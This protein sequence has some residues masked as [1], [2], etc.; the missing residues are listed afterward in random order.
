MVFLEPPRATLG[1]LRAALAAASDDVVT[2][3]FDFGAT[4]TTTTTTTDGNDDDDDGGD[5]PNDE[6][7]AYVSTLAS[8]LADAREWDAKVWID[9]LSPYLLPALRSSSGYPPE[10]PDGVVPSV[11]SRLRDAARDAAA[12]HDDDSSDEEDEYG[13]EE[14][15]D[16][17]FSLAYGGKILLHQTKLRLRRGHRYALVGQ[18]GVGKTTLMNAI[19]AGKLEGWPAEL[20]T[21]YVDSGS[22]VDPDHEAKVAFDHLVKITGKSDDECRGLLSQLKFTDAMMSGTIGELSGGWQMKLR[23]AQAVLVDADILLLDEPTNHLDTKT[24]RWLVDYLAGLTQTTVLIVSHD[25]PFL[26]EV[27]SDGE[28]F[29]LFFFSRGRRVSEGRADGGFVNRDLTMPGRTRY[30]PPTAHHHHN[31]PPTHTRAR[32]RSA[33]IHYEQ[34]PQWGPHRKLVHYAGRMS[35]FVKKQPQAKH[36]FELATTDLKFVFP[37][38]GRLEGIR[39]ST[40]RFLEME[41]VNYRYPGCDRDTLTDINLKMTLSSRVCLVGAN[42]AGK[43]TLVKMIVGDTQP[44]NPSDCRFFIHHNLRI[45]YV[46][47]HAFYHVEQHVDDSPAAYIQWRFK[48]GY[49]KVRY[50]IFATAVFPHKRRPH[51]FFP[52]TKMTGR[53]TTGKD[54]ERGVPNRTRGAEGHRRLQPRGDMEPSPARRRARVRDQEEERARE[55]QYIREQGRAPRHGIQAPTAPDGREDREQGGRARPAPLHDDGD[56]EAP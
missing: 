15:T 37:D 54:R 31:P 53:I 29:L 56:P 52:P 35:A 38:P 18:N 48:D 41:G 45:A 24:V 26:E 39:T 23:L 14:I 17:R 33:V 55:G 8:A 13:G 28:S 12:G 7:L 20:T 3:Q 1:L 51:K 34:R 22:N 10:D 2:P 49:D 46:S 5:D 25:T 36:Y 42:G 47:Q 40:Q 43:T 44:S 21:E 30:D 4:T 19:N 9:E 16:I 11:V 27:C 50:F 6:V 32:A